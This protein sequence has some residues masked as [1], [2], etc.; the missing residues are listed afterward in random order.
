MAFLSFSD[1]LQFHVTPAILHRML[2]KVTQT[3]CG[4]CLT[5]MSCYQLKLVTNSKMKNRMLTDFICLIKTPCVFKHL[6]SCHQ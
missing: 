3:R 5:F 2:Q 6:V 1:T 4:F